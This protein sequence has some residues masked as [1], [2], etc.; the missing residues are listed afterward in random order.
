MDGE[1]AATLRCALPGPPCLRFVRC[2]ISFWPATH[3]TQ[4][5]LTS[6][7]RTAR[8]VAPGTAPAG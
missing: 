3:V 1:E 2:T 6:L 5:A 4:I 7:G 8:A